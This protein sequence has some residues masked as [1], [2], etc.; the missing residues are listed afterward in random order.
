MPRHFQTVNIGMVEILQHLENYKQ[1]P[2]HIN[3]YDFESFKNVFPLLVTYK[4]RLAPD[5]VRQCDLASLAYGFP[6]LGTY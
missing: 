1:R 6:S 4:Q 3:R 5:H 2:D